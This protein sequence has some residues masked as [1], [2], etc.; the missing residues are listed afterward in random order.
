M[1]SIK[2]LV[3]DPIS[4]NAINLL[5]S[6][7]L[8]VDEKPEISHEELKRIIEQYH[9]LIVRSRTKV[10]RDII[11][12]GRNL[13]IIARAGVGLDNIDV[14]YAKSKGITI[15]NAPEAPTIAVAELTIGLMIAIARGICLGNMALKEGKW[16]KKQL[17][18]FELYGK[19][20]GIIGFGRIGKEV[21]KRAKAFGMN[22]IAISRRDISREA[23]ELGVEAAKDLDDLLRKSDI[24]TLHVPL[25]PKTYHMIGEREF[26]IM[27]DGVVII[28][29][30]RGAVIDGKALLKALKSGKVYAA[31]LDVYEHEPPQED[32]EW[33]L[34][35]HPRVIAVPHIGAQTREAQEKAGMIIAEKILKTLNI[36]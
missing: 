5:K 32:W 14:E 22:V 1:S 34:I 17:M 4:E 25:T 28:N 9:V 12:S 30:A 35:R 23:R 16:I 13:K 11:D 33:E 24:I 31:G 20:L 8:I 26:S 36:K 15:L 21:A 18:G 2:V 3:S 27:K 6:K 7:G 29:T 19:T 10:T